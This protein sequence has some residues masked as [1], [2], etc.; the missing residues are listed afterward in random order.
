VQYPG[1]LT[2]E[3]LVPTDPDA[4]YRKSQDL[5]ASHLRLLVV[6]LGGDQTKP[7]HNGDW[8]EKLPPQ[9]VSRPSL[10]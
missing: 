5:F 1:R 3:L 9:L 8:L 7:I 6:Q 10:A 4:K 2:S